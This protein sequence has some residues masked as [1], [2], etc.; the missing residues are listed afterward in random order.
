VAIFHL[1]VKTVSRSAGRSAVAAAAYRAGERLLDHRSGLEHDYAR[2]A[3]DE[4]FILTPEGAEWAQDRGQL[5]NAAE[6]AEV[7]KNATVA[8]EY[9]LALPAELTR[10]QRSAL[11]RGFGQELVERYGVAVDVGIHAPDRQGDQRN[12]HAHV[13]TT[14]RTVGPEGLGEKTRVLDAKATG[15]GE[16]E[17]LRASWAR[18]T[19]EAL[20]R[21]QVPERVDHR[22]HQRQGLDQTPTVHLG[23][24]VV[25]MERRAMRE[26]GFSREGGQGIVQAMSAPGFEPATE[27]GRDTVMVGIGNQLRE[28][29]RAAERSLERTID[30]A[31]EVAGPLLGKVASLFEQQQD[32][33][34][35]A[36]IASPAVQRGMS[37]LA[38][39]ARAA[40]HARRQGLER[41][42]REAAAPELQAFV[43]VAHE[44]APGRSYDD[45]HAGRSLDPNLK[46]A[47][48]R[49]NRLDGP[50]Q[51]RML[52]Q[53]ARGVAAPAPEMP[54]LGPLLKIVQSLRAL[55]RER[56]QEITL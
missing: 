44:R 51:E 20:E 42:W 8:R 36:S 41:G 24:L 55:T 47:A 5:W 31:K 30:R 56:T 29:A 54:G 9:E 11:V 32:A 40:E 35:A 1:S 27:R 16:V 6:A 13:L 46:R 25:G 39:Q 34:L 19:N 14:T 53:I 33:G 37:E 22:S 26:Q 38:G 15:P 23:P 2:K 18:H 12:W 4:T 48:D 17:I 10:E 7:R 45:N 21:V 28:W 43:E 3:V 49:F 52:T 50:G